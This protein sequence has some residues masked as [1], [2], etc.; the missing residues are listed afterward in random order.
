[1]PQTVTVQLDT[2]PRFLVDYG[3]KSARMVEQPTLQIGP[4]TVPLDTYLG[5]GQLQGTVA[6]GLEVGRYDVRVS[7]GDG[8]ETTLPDAYEVKAGVADFWL[9][10]IGPQVQ[11]QPFTITIHAAGSGAEHFEG[12]VM[13]S[14]YKD[15]VTTSSM[16]SGAFAAGMRQ[17]NLTIDSTGDNYLVIIDDG[18][19]N[20]A[21]SNSFR[22]DPKI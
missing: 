6:S 9:E 4:Q 18:H 14:I 5:H 17:E 15:G 22:V 1:K 16:Q 8:R 10:S 7:L 11:D 20:G 21:T 2:D 19:G 13:V 3:S 12:T